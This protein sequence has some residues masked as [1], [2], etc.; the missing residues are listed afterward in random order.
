MPGL[1]R[2]IVFCAIAGALLAIIAGSAPRSTPAAPQPQSS[3]SPIQHLVVIYLENW[4]FDG[5]YGTFPGADGLTP[6][7]GTPTPLPQANKTGTPLPDLGRVPMQ[8]SSC[9]AAG[10]TTPLPNRPFDLSPVVPPHCRTGGVEHRFYNEQYQ[11]NGGL[12]NMFHAWDGGDPPALSLSYYDMAGVATQPS[13][14]RTPVVARWAQQYTLADRWFHAAFGDSWLNHFWLVCACTPEWF[15]TGPP[16]SEIIIPTITPTTGQ[17][18]TD[19]NG[20]TVLLPNAV[21]QLT[22]YIVN[23]PTSDPCPAVLA[24]PIPTFTPT[25]TPA[26][27]P[28]ATCVPLQVLPNIGDRLSQAGL[29]WGWYRA[30]IDGVVPSFQNYARNT[31]GSAEHMR[32]IAHTPTATVT[33]TGTRATSTPTPTGTII[34]SPTTKPPFLDVV[35]TPG[36]LAPV[37][38]IRPSGADSEHPENDALSPGEAFVAATLVPAIMTSTP[39]QQNRVAIVITYDENGGRWDHVAPPNTLTPATTPGKTDRFGPGS[40]VP[41]I[42][43]SPWARRCYIDRT[44]YDTT[45]IAA[46]IE[47][48]WNLPPLSTRDAAADPLSGA[49]D[50]SSPPLPPGVCAGSPTPT[51]TVTVPTTP[52]IH[53]GTQTAIVQTATV[54]ALTATATATIHPGTQTAI[55]QTATIQALTTTATPTIH[56]LTQTAIV[57]TATAQALTAT[58]LAQTPTPTAQPSTTPTASPTTANNLTP[59]QAQTRAQGTAGFQTSTAGVPCALAIGQTCTVAGAVTGTLTRTGSMSFTLTAT[60]PSGLLAG[61]TPVAVFSTDQGLQAVTCAPPTAGAGGTAFTCTG[62]I[63]GNAL[64]GSTAALCFTATTTCLLGTVSGAG[65]TIVVPNQPLLPPPVQPLPPLPPPLLLPPPPL[66]AVPPVTGPAPAPD[67]PVIPE[68]E[69]LLLLGLGLA[70]LGLLARRRR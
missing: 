11:I 47:K 60:V 64:A 10:L 6:G 12:M 17:F 29:D 37:S 19:S 52:T 43:I 63:A 4:S 14:T 18:A 36:A 21:G 57:Q 3:T 50:F 20:S 7:P 41:A 15:G 55:V 49:F 42:I 22:W 69:S 1:T 33:V 34:P 30:D 46:F 45:S 44:W 27:S 62:A 32:W 58:V 56:P 2:A 70:A 28:T 61:L 25:A 16:Q 23:Q 54:Q 24:S 68:A 9:T 8:T 67:V 26:A 5:L 40:R 13:L 39:Y 35:K 31:L 51:G 66:P 59:A 38:F 53:P 65:T 48:N